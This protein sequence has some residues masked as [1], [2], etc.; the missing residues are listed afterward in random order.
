MFHYQDDSIARIHTQRFPILSPLKSTFSTLSIMI[1]KSSV[2]RFDV[3]SMPAHTELIINV[4]NDD[5]RYR[6]SKTND[7]SLSPMHK[8]VDEISNDVTYIYKLEYSNKN[9]K[10]NHYEIEYMLL[11]ND[12]TNLKTC[13]LAELEISVIDVDSLYKHMSYGQCKLR[14]HVHER[15]SITSI[16]LSLC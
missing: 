3:F 15:V 6:K 9:G 1:Q 2:L 12:E 8:I 11:K 14:T 4:M 16:F 13:P 5:I 7:I 10:F